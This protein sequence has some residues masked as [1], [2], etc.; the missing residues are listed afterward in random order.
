MKVLV[1]CHKSEGME[2]VIDLA[3]HYC[4]AFNASVFL[5][6]SLVVSSLDEENMGRTSQSYLESIKSQFVKMG[7]TCETRT[8]VRGLSEGEDII[9]YARE[10]DVNLIIMGVRKRSKISKLLLGSLTQYVIL[11]ADCP[12]LTVNLE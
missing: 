2:K 8:S 3:K 6:Q 12:V 4:A 5:I 1:A 7:I 10:K 11:T 9:E